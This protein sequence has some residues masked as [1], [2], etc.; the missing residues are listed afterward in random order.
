MF[1]IFPSH[2]TSLLRFNI[3]NQITLKQSNAV[4][5]AINFWQIKENQIVGAL[6]IIA[7]LDTT[8]VNC[9]D[10]RGSIHQNC[11]GASTV[12]NILSWSLV[13]H[14]Q[15]SL[16]PTFPL[17][18][19]NI[20]VEIPQRL[21]FEQALLS[22]ASN[23]A[24][25]KNRFQAFAWN[26]LT[27][28]KDSN[29]ASTQILHR[30]LKVGVHNGYN[31][32]RN[33]WRII[34]LEEGRISDLLTSSNKLD[35]Q[36]FIKHPNCAIVFL[37]EYE[38]ETDNVT[39]VVLGSTLCPL[40]Y[41]AILGM[42]CSTD[43]EFAATLPVRSDSRCLSFTD[44]PIFSQNKNAPLLNFLISSSNGLIAKEDGV[45]SNQ[46]SE[47][48]KPLAL[49]N[50]SH[51][52]FLD[53]AT[54]GTLSEHHK[55]KE[56]KDDSSSQFSSSN[57]VHM[58]GSS[59]F[60]DTST[61]TFGDSTAIEDA[62]DSHINEVI[63]VQSHTSAT[64]TEC[65]GLNI[66]ASKETEDMNTITSISLTCTSYKT[67]GDPRRSLS[68][69]LKFHSMEEIVTDSFPLRKAAN[70]AVLMFSNNQL[71]FGYDY[72]TMDAAE[73]TDFINYLLE[74]HLFV[75]LFEEELH[76][77]TMALPMY[78][79]LRQGKETQLLENMKV[80]VVGPRGI[81][82]DTNRLHIVE[83]KLVG[84]IIAQLTLSIKCE[85]SRGER[86]PQYTATRSH[87]L[88]LLDTSPE[89]LRII[90]DLHECY[91]DTKTDSYVSDV[92]NGHQPET[93][94]LRR[95]QL[96][97]VQALQ[98]QHQ[99]KSD[100]K[101]DID[102]LGSFFRDI[103]SSQG[104][105]D[106]DLRVLQAVQWYREGKKKSNIMKHIEKQKQKGDIIIRP[107][108]GQ[109]ILIE[110][111]F[112]NPISADSTSPDHETFRIEG[113]PAI[114]L[115]SNSAEW[116]SR[117]KAA[118]A[119]V[120][121]GKENL[122]KFESIEDDR[123]KL[124]PHETV[125]LPLAFDCTTLEQTRFAISFVTV[126]KNIVCTSFN[127]NVYP[128]LRTD[129]RLLISC[130]EN[131][132]IQRS[133]IFQPKNVQNEDQLKIKCIDET[134]TRGVA[135]EWAKKETNQGNAANEIRFDFQCP[136]RSPSIETCYILISNDNFNSILE[137]WHVEIKATG[138]QTETVNC[139][140]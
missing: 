31:L 6:T 1:S 20:A 123:I 120:L 49:D 122:L 45:E 26:K 7:G 98:R 14:G 3:C 28:K 56:E 76:V 139:A 138:G 67:T 25:P 48:G 11:I 66:S 87:A 44:K 136:G 88:N 46:N 82:N 19:S 133:I 117:R 70:E 127:I 94:S 22:F 124:H 97:A 118:G 38:F 108:L 21:E 9:F 64:K 52:Q 107:W 140:K 104:L 54:Q 74:R 58:K 24:R 15:V 109:R 92:R 121:A 59:S 134:S 112:T 111:E 72:S 71:P 36:G 84:P 47:N 85:G 16:A 116:A 130:D 119:S 18:I 4:F 57:N 101:N 41:D 73:T 5:A 37:V 12:G 131:E 103:T 89:L 35:I 51:S 105:F 8:T 100:R 29:R 113:H 42:K 55:N 96:K 91:G 27:D 13:P 53:V 77:G 135:C 83:G 110:Y 129:R 33:Q 30:R 69:R 68:F 34:D 43:D 62:K 114:H 137:C 2:N 81:G 115:I 86:V 60:R 40:L 65:V 90:A 93:Q 63:F 128:R 132:N 106:V 23:N 32:L 39:T 80:D 78:L 50:S 102:S 95:Q 99:K 75:D 17:K 61:L 125:V 79:F 126:D 10:S